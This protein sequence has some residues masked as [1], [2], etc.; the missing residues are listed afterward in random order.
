MQLQQLWVV[1]V[2]AAAAQRSVGG[3]FRL[4]FKILFLMTLDGEQECHTIRHAE[5]MF[6]VSLLT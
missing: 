6:H 4:F 5:G 2:V 1:V 3:F